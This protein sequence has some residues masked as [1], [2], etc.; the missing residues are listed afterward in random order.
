VLAAWPAAGSPAELAAALAEDGVKV[1]ACR[2]VPG[3]L[4][5]V[6]GVP[7]RTKAFRAGAFWIQDEASQ[8]A[9][10][11]FGQTLGPRV[12]DA[13]AAPGGKTLALAARTCEGGFVLAAD[14][15]AGRLARLARNLGRLRAGNVTPLVCD[16]S[17]RAPFRDFFDEVL[18]DAPCSG[19]GTLR[20]HPEIRWRLEPAD[21]EVYRA[22]QSRILGHAAEWVRPGGK[23]VYSVCSIEPEEGDAVVAGFLADRPEFT[24]TDPRGVLTAEAGTRIGDDLALRTSPLDDGI[25]GFFAV[26][27]TRRGR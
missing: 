26:L 23:L 6:S 15:H 18:V 19:T 1:A 7:Q 11:L 24:R 14:R 12:L 2:L 17:K 16:L 3:A 9:P 21:L 8:L 22:R 27:L 13:C 25:D 4:R 5:V 10:L 20:R